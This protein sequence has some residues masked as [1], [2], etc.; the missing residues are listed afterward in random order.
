M[1]SSIHSSKPEMSS[2]HISSISLGFTRWSNMSLSLGFRDSDDVFGLEDVLTTSDDHQSIT[3]ALQPSRFIGHRATTRSANHRARSPKL[4]LL[5][6]DLM[7]TWATPSL[8]SKRHHDRFSCFHTQVTAENPY[9]L[10]WAPLSPK[11]AHSPGGICMD[12]I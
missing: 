2:V 5:M 9:T 8:Q 3:C 6:G 11:I 1:L 7:S 4:P 10:Q 12:P